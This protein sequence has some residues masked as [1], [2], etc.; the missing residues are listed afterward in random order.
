M[1]KTKICGMILSIS[2][3]TCLTACN[4]DISEDI[5]P[6]NN[7]SDEKVVD[8]TPNVLLPSVMINGKIYYL[9]GEEAAT[10][11]D[12]NSYSGR[13]KSVVSL[14]E[15]PTKDDEAN[16]EPVDSPYVLLDDGNAIVWFNGRWM[17]F[18]KMDE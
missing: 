5:I 11:P 16:F 7:L 9:F 15:F 2:I 17:L 10:V 18:G 12:E 8:E 6:N 14:T 3:L 13:I 4:N 1:K